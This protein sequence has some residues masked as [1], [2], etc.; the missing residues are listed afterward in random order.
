M[1]TCCNRTE[2][3]HQVDHLHRTRCGW[4]HV[5]IGKL[6]VGVGGFGLPLRPR[7]GGLVAVEVG[8][9]AGVGAV[10]AG[11]GGDWAVALPA[12]RAETSARERAILVMMT[13]AFF[14][15]SRGRF[16]RL[17]YEEG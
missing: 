8:G 7:L 2:A 14:G 1:R 13:R 12:S 9:G 4:H 10:A 11:T 16:S 3:R 17:V 5:L 6:R 15:G